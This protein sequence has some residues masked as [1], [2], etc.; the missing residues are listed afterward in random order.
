MGSM[1]EGFTPPASNIFQ[2]ET[3]KTKKDNKT[4]IEKNKAEISGKYVLVTIGDKQY[5]IMPINEQKIKQVHQ[6]LENMIRSDSSKL[7]TV[8]E[9]IAMNPHD[10]T[11]H[12]ELQE[13][14]TTNL[15]I[16]KDDQ[17]QK[18]T[19]TS[20]AAG[21]AQRKQSET[22]GAKIAMSVA[23]SLSPTPTT[24]P[25]SSLASTSPEKSVA[26]TPSPEAVQEKLKE[27]NKAF[28]H[29]ENNLV[30]VQDNI[31]WWKQLSSEEQREEANIEILK[32]RKQ[33]AKG[34]FDEHEKN[35]KELGVK[36][37][38]EQNGITSLHTGHYE[39]LE[40]ANQ[41]IN[42][43]KA[44]SNPLISKDRPHSQG[45]LDALKRA[46]HRHTR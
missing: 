5:K 29:L 26:S 13:E 23:P 28:S 11:C 30:V 39:A 14:H 31:K 36:E 9:K 37:F 12:I 10:K 27:I 22:V 44:P 1:P 34:Y 24:L 4:E 32:K 15:I 33:D 2:A 40:K 21:E 25:S 35:M 17:Q 46:R 6:G 3:E 18:Y 19:F 20:A 45:T 8:L 38:F 41:D 43:L 7:Q 16:G 42:A